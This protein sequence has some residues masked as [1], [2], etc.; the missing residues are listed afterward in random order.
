D[1]YCDQ[2][3][4]D[5][6][7]TPDTTDNF[8]PKSGETD[9]EYVLGGTNQPLAISLISFT[10]D[11][12]ADRE[13]IDIAWETATEV[14]TIGFYL[15]RSTSRD[16]EYEKIEDSFTSAKSVNSTQ[17]AKYAYQDCNV[18]L[19]DDMNYFYKLEEVDMDNTKKNPFYGPIGPVSEHGSADQVTSA[20]NRSNSSDSSSTCFI[21]TLK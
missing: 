14:E 1:H 13:C 6:G 18:Y 20:K 3:W 17:G 4:V 7:A 2:T 19:G 12:D 16:G 9:T 8:L 11:P 5:T 10:A 21:S 15:W